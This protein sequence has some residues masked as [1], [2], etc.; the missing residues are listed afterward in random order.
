MDLSSA[1]KF[2]TAQTNGLKWPRLEIP[3]A[4]TGYL[5]IIQ[6]FDRADSTPAVN[7]QRWL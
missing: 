1:M 4:N 6:L 3:A 2:M 5:L 7:I